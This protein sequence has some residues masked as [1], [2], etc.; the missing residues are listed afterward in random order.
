M[1]FKEVSETLNERGLEVASKELKFEHFSN[2]FPYY[3]EYFTGQKNG[4]FY[5][6]T[7]VSA[8]FDRDSVVEV[9]LE[10][11]CTKKNTRRPKNS[12]LKAK[13]LQDNG[14]SPV[15]VKLARELSEIKEFFYDKN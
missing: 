5:Y 12:D 6:A 9:A 2:P 10:V 1:K 4:F 8:P 3:A 7:V 13:F 11:F 15:E 14:F